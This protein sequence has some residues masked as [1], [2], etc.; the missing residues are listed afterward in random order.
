MGYHTKLDYSLQTLK[1]QTKEAKKRAEKNKKNEIAL[2]ASK[3]T[4]NEFFNP[5]L[6][7]YHRSNL[8]SIQGQIRG[9]K[10]D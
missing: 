1:Q 8:K 4:P 5:S 3:I 9:N 2:N 10:H 6:T 7:I